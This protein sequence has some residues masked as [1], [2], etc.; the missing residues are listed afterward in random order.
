MRSRPRVRPQA[1]RAVEGPGICA[2]FCAQRDR[3]PS[4]SA[5]HARVVVSCLVRARNTEPYARSRLCIGGLGRRVGSRWGP[6][7]RLLTPHIHPPISVRPLSQFRRRD[8]PRILHGKGRIRSHAARNPRRSCTYPPGRVLRI[9][10]SSL[11]KT[12]SHKGG[13]IR[14]KMDHGPKSLCRALL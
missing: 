3:C 7:V 1:L 14:V 13:V 6:P 11:R 10:G 9:L 8:H 5:L 12:R 4:G 2:Q